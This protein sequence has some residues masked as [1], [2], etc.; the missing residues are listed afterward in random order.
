MWMIINNKQSWWQ[1]EAIEVVKLNKDPMYAILA[2][3]Y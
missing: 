1:L 2:L 3:V